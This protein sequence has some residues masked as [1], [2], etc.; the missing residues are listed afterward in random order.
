[1]RECEYYQELMSRLLDDDLTAEEQAALREHVRTCPDCRRT[2]AAFTGMTQ[3]LR[4]DRAEPPRDLAKGVMER[5]TDEQ[6]KPDR[7][8]RRGPSSARRTTRSLSPWVRLGAAACL[9]L[10]VAGAA[11]AALRGG[12]TQDAVGESAAA[13]TAEAMVQK[14]APEPAEEEAAGVPMTASIQDAAEASAESA[15]DQ[16]ASL[17][18]PAPD[19]EP[20]PVY[21]AA[22]SRIGAIPPENIAAFTQLITDAGWGE[23][24]PPD[25]QWEY[26]LKVEY[27]RKTYAFATDPDSGALV[28]WEEPSTDVVRSPGTL[29]GLH[30]LITMDAPALPE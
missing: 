16:D 4:E 5:I 1:M 26:L 11:T 27:Q 14:D 3:A 23:D 17:S 28:W 2:L 13:D 10:L 29:A 9:V 30:S 20:L 18:T 15:P 25:V 6:A 12:R 8:G 24:G 22:R 7:P 19:P 21:D